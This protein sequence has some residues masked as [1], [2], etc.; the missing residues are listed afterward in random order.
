MV[1]NGTSFLRPALTRCT[2]GARGPGT[3]GTG[4]WD[5][6]ANVCELLEVLIERGYRHVSGGRSRGD[7]A[8]H[9][10]DLRFSITI[11][12]V[13]VNRGSAD[14]H[15]GAGDEPAEHRCDISTRALIEGFQ[16]KHALGQNSRQHHNQHFAAIA[17][18][19]QL[20]RSLGMLF[21]VLHQIADD[22]IGVDKPSFAHRVPSRRRAAFTAAWRISAKDIPL[23]FLLARA[24]LRERVPRCTRT[25]MWSPSRTYS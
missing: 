3:S 24:P 15:T 13:D 25:V 12:G 14:F 21:M 18:V 7:Q 16:H 17:C 19:E 5:F 6:H 1:G 10:M 23:P 9:E 20:S 8:V 22:Q 4:L 2:S 11:Q